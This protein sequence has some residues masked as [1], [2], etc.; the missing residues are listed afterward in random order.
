MYLNQVI[1]HSDKLK[2]W[3]I[4]MIQRMIIQVLQTR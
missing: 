1:L 3:V 2:L 4:S